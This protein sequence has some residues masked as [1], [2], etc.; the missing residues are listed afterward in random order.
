MANF[1]IILTPNSDEDLMYQWDIT[2]RDIEQAQAQAKAYLGMSGTR[3]KSATILSSW[4]SS[5][6]WRQAMNPIIN[7]F[8]L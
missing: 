7:N 1:R 4:K 6:S 3:F 2:C 8:N 5:T